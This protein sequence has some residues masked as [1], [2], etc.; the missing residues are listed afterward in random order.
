MCR[1]VLC[2]ALYIVNS[3]PNGCHQPGAEQPEPVGYLVQMIPGES[4]FMPPSC[5]GHHTSIL[6]H[7]QGFFVFDDSCVLV[8]TNSN[9]EGFF[10]FLNAWSG[11]GMP[12]PETAGPDTSQGLQHVHVCTNA[13]LLSY[14]ENKTKKIYFSKISLPSRKNYKYF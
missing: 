3:S 12:E 6:T 8:I 11:T 14:N 13:C 4:L 10:F 5:A 9:T 2:K 1:G 7:S